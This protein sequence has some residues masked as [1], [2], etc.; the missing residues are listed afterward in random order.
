[1][2]PGRERGLAKG[3]TAIA[4]HVPCGDDRDMHE[5]ASS[6]GVTRVTP[7][8][9]SRSASRAMNENGRA[10]GGADL[11]D[12][13]PV[14]PDPLPGEAA[15]EIAGVEEDTGPRANKATT[16]SPG[17]STLPNCHAREPSRLF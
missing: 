7:W 2:L 13:R 9:E 12:I 10:H 17:P 6:G 15:V 14:E 5:Q 8:G 16:A 4:Y 1:M 3:G 11:E